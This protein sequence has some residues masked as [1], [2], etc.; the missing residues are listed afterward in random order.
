MTPPS[1]SP[2]LDLILAL[3]KRFEQEVGVAT[4]RRIEHF[5]LESERSMP[6]EPHY[7]LGILAVTPPVQRTGV[8]S[9]LLREV[10]RISDAD[11]ESRGVCLTTEIEE[12]VG[13]YCQRGYRVLQKTVIGGVSSWCMFRESK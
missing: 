13:Y 2:K 1:A 5:E 7:F 8:G 11:P 4:F 10:Q 6:E 12:N 9:Q 3:Q